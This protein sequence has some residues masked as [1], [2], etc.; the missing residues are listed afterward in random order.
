MI[1]FQL[2]DGARCL[3]MIR[4]FRDERE[5]HGPKVAIMKI[6]GIFLS[7]IKRIS[8][9]ALPVFAAIVFL[10]CACNI[11]LSVASPA[12]KV[13]Q[14]KPTPSDA[15]GPFYKQDAPIRST[16]G[17]GYV[18]AGTVKSAASCSPVPEAQIEFWLAGPDGKYHDAQRATVIA[19]NSG[20]Y[21]FESNFPPPYMSRP[22]HIHVKV[23]AKGFNG[24]VTQYYPAKGEH[25]GAFDLVL[26]P[27]G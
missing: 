22:S 5:K 26:E 10:V 7:K 15:L 11:G 12:Q 20:E 3:E 1:E 17:E 27:A 16:V 18:L 24:L 4:F 21:R 14:C 6:S 2:V 25:G 23:T 9:S 19:G 8:L 13:C